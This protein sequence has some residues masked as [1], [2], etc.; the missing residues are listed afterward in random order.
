[1]G[2]SINNNPQPPTPA[3]FSKNLNATLIMKVQSPLGPTISTITQSILLENLG[4]PHL[5][6]MLVRNAQKRKVPTCEADSGTKTTENFT[7]GK[8]YLSIYGARNQA[9]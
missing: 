5:D 4:K 8:S 3:F 7:P 9:I 1:M 6:P 2:L